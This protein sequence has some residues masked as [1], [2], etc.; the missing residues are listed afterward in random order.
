MSK[1][2]VSIMWREDR[3]RFYMQYRDPESGDKIRQSTD[4]SNRR[5]A[6]RAAAKWE[7]K[8]REDLESRR[9]G[10]IP[11]SEFRR[12]Y[13]DEKLTGLAA[14]TDAKAVGVFNV[15]ERLMKP[16]LLSDI[17]TEYLG[18]YQQRLRDEKRAETTIKSHLAH[19]RAALNW[20]VEAKMLPRAPKVPKVQR[21]KS[22]RV[23][24]GRPI[25]SEEFE[26]M[27]AKT[28]DVVGQSR[29]E[30]WIRLQRGLWWSGLRLSEAMELHWT[31]T[32]KLRV[33]LSCRHPM[34]IIRAELEKGHKDRILPIAPEFATFLLE[35]PIRDRHGFVFNPQPERVRHERMGVQQVSRVI[36]MIGEK[37]VVKVSS[38]LVT[39]DGKEVEKVKWASAH[40]LRR[41]FG[42]RWAVRVM[43]QVLQELMRHES[44]ETTLRY[45]VGRSAQ[46]T[47]GILWEAFRSVGNHL[48][49]RDKKRTRESSQVLSE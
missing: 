46:A 21:A 5:Q 6:E 20:A 22:S 29:A 8:L 27:L 32:N 35:T 33:D 26:R 48:G 42:D 17:T 34:L 2:T 43:P 41:S 1:I 18:R 19:L 10:K 16:R 31:D 36:G 13:E 49:N 7:Q 4:T 30:S 3:Q 12:R 15:F 38:K 39:V 44:I 14:R 11:W 47:A 40:D 23:M 24:K 28:D 37:A 9:Y 45:Y 25:S